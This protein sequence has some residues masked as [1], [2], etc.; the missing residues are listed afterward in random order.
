M[1]PRS[2]AT[3]FRPASVSSLARMPPVQPSPTMT[4]STSLSFMVMARPSTH[5]RDAD[6]LGRER[7]AS[8][9]LHMVA[10]HRNDAGKTDDRP[11]CLVAIAAVDRVGI[12][13]FDHGLIKR[14]PESPH[15]QPVVESDFSGG[16]TD[17]YLLAL[18]DFDPVKRFA[19]RLAAMRVGRL[20]AG[21]IELRGRQRQLKTLARGALLP[22]ALHVQ[23]LTL[24]PGAGECAI[25]VNID[26]EVG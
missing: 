6:R 25:D 7:L 1:A 16:Q 15:R 3:T 14:R 22:G 17:Q 20:D 5:V 11:S 19:V 23:A 18:R 26:A 10:M 2:S 21:T 4:T 13:A 8:I 24:A 9:F 12:D